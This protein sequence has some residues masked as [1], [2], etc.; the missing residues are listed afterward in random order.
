MD[1]KTFAMVCYLCLM[2]HHGDGWQNAHPHYIEEKRVILESGFSAFGFLDPV[3][4]KCVLDY[5]LQWGLELPS[6]IEKFIF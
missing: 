1:E 3:N 2:A 4:Q 6:E 5:F